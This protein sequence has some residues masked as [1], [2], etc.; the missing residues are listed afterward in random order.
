MNNIEKIIDIIRK[1]NE[2]VPTMS[3]GTSGFTNSSNSNGPVAGYDKPMD[4]VRKD[5]KTL[6]FRRRLPKKLPAEYQNL[7]RRQT[8]V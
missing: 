3:A 2:E 6:D 8:S 4:F 5:Q 7:F 1:L